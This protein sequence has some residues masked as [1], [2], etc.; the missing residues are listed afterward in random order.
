MEETAI[1]YRDLALACLATGYISIFYWLMGH[2]VRGGLR[3]LGALG[4]IL[5]TIGM[6]VFG[7]LA[8]ITY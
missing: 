3:E 8:I 7:I 6:V 1:L 4:I 2:R 5:S